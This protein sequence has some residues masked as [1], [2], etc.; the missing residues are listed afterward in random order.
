MSKKIIVAGGGLVGSLI[1]VLLSKQGH[2]VQ[3]HEKRPDPRGHALSGG[4]SINLALSHRGFHA[5]EQA[6]LKHV[7]KPLGVPMYG[8]AIHDN[9]GQ[10][11]FQ[12]YGEEGQAIWSVSR[13]KLNEVLIDHA[14]Q[15]AWLFF[16]QEFIRSNEQEAVFS[17]AGK[18]HSYAHDL[19]L[20]CD[21]AHSNV[22][23]QVKGATWAEEQLSHQYTE[24]HIPPDSETGDF[25]LDANA[26]HIWP[27][28]QFMLIA[29][30]NADRS[31]TA[32]LFLAAKG[33]P[34]FASLADQ[35]N[36]EDFLR[37]QF[38]DAMQC[39]PDLSTQLSANP[40]SSLSTMYVEKWWDDT[41]MLLGDAAHAI[42][43][44]YGQGMNAG[45]EDCRIFNEMI[46]KHGLSSDMLQAF[47]EQRKPDVDAIAQLAL[48]NFIEMRDKVADDAFLKRKQADQLLHE[49]F[50]DD[51][52]T[53][54]GMV[55]FSDTPYH[56]A[57]ERGEK[58]AR[59]LDDIFSLEGFDMDWLKTPV[60]PEVKAK[61][62]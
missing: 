11:T 25:A 10:V 14:G 52:Q 4:R 50:P 53:Q 62:F 21:G 6:G 58:Q 56:K 34:S 47:Y 60:H 43:P 12:P 40:V 8:R 23:K 55:T 18:E 2:Q 9:E 24:L 42:V 29:L 26:L 45:F 28:R 33:N 7:I 5:L 51:W 32:T 15:H 19:L 3:L 57:L 39:I 31:F 36:M 20:G 54:Y 61:L 1:T 16:E 17:E 59:L 41:T 44:F 49:A 37:E 22:R 13:N 38:P 48:D 27:R 46:K 30:P 35:G